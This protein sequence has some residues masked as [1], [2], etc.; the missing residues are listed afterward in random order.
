MDLYILFHYSEWMDVHSNS[1]ENIF[2]IEVKFFW[3]FLNNDLTDYFMLFI[4]NSISRLP[5]ALQNTHHA[6]QSLLSL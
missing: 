2:R 6:A 1:Q 4:L 3:K 5:Y